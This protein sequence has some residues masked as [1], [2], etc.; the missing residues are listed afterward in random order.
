MRILDFYLTLG[1]ITLVGEAFLSQCKTQD[2]LICC[3]RTI[4]KNSKRKVQVVPQSQAA[5]LPKQQEEEETDKTKQAQIEQTYEK[6]LVVS[7]PS[8]VIAM[9]KGLKQN[10]KTNKQKTNKQ[11]NKQKNNNTRTK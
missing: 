4:Y 6:R 2:F 11:T 1:R 5:A 3:A 7:F 9:L 8:E 10:K